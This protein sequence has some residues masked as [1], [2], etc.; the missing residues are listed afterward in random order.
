MMSALR[1]NLQGDTQ[2]ITSHTTSSNNKQAKSF[3]IIP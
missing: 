3:L 1:H 2:L